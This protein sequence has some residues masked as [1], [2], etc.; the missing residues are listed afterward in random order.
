MSLQD[1]LKNKRIELGMTMAELAKKVGVSE[2]T[3]SRW[4]SGD[5]ANMKRDKIVLLAKALHVSP[6]FIMGMDDNTSQPL[7]NDKDEK[8]IARVLSNTLEKLSYNSEAL[9]FDG[10]A[11]D[12]ETQ[13]LLKNS[14][15]NALRM[16]KVI[17]KQKYNP[18]KNQK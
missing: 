13:E 1:D 17:A 8:D 2:A 4:E 14:L 11:L 7:L 6:I 9:M 10:E 5:I 18:K 15:E 12:S 3:I 16:G